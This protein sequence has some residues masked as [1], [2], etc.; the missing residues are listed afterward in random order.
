[1]QIKQFTVPLLLLTLILSVSGCAK[2]EKKAEP[3]IRPVRYAKVFI[4][5]GS[6][7]RTFSGTAQAGTESNL[8]FKVAGTVTKVAVQVGDKVKKGNLLAEIDPK[9]Y[10]LQVQEAEASL[11]QAQAGLRNAKTS[12]ERVQYLYE[13]RNAAKQ[14]LDGA[15]A[16]YESADAQVRS[17]EKRLQLAKLQV[18][19]CRLVAPSAGSIARVEVEVNENVGAGQPVF[20]MT[21]GSK[22]EVRVSVPEVLIS[23]IKN[24][25]NA[26]VTFDALAGK[27]FSA[28][29]SEVGVSST[30][31][32][33]TFP[34]TV[35]LKK[36][37]SE[38]RPGMAA[39]VGFRFETA[40]TQER[41]IVPAVAVGEDREGRF[42][43]IVEP[44]KEGFATT[45][46]A[47]VKIGDL[48]TEGLEILEG[49]QEGDLVVTAGVSKIVD[50]QKVRLL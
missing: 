21:S 43:F 27:E 49:L 44:A 34:V 26:T 29:V 4:T 42:V 16:N 18:Q 22:P 13:N 19:Y 48:T 17:I 6:R 39:E 7:I 9:D 38:I 45:R 46:R 36:A 35:Q 8:S 5:G 1:M 12:Y 24:G 30:S 3:I 14:D 15:R 10:R 20:T 25:S 32:A 40:G 28:V 37:T 11:Q 33:T 50:G 41:L 47:A 31:F 23:Q 2:E